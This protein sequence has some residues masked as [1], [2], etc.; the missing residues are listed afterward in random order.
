MMKILRKIGSGIKCM[1]GRTA[2]MLILSIVLVGILF[3][4][5]AF[6]ATDE[7]EKAL[8]KLQEMINTGFG[9]VH[10]VFWPILLMLG[11]LMDNDLIFGQEIGERLREIWVVIRNMVNIAFVFVLL[12]IA[13][14]NVTGLGGEGN[15]A[16]KTALPKFV[17]A[18]IAVNFSFL[19]CKVILDAAN[20]VSMAVYDIA[21]SI[22]AEEYEA[23]A[24]KQQLE[25][26]L[27]NSST[28][29]ACGRKVAPD[30]SDSG[31][32]NTTEEGMDAATS[33]EGAEAASASIYA[34]IAAECTEET[35]ETKYSDANP[36]A[37]AFC[38]SSNTD[39]DTPCENVAGEAVTAPQAENDDD[40]LIY[41]AFNDAGKSFFMQLDQNNIGIIMAINLGSLNHLTEVSSSGLSGSTGIKEI[42]IN[43]LFSVLMY[44]VFG[45][46]YIALFIVLLARLVVLW[47]VIALSPI[48][49]LT[50]VLPQMSQYTSELN[51]GEKFVQHL[52]APIIIGLSMSIGFLM[53]DKLNSEGA[54]GIDMGL[55]GASSYSALKDGS[56]TGTFLAPNISDL[57]QLMIACIAVAVVWLGVF[58]AADKTIASSVTSPIKD[59]GTKAAKFIA[60]LPTY[61]PIVPIMTKEGEEAKPYSFSEITS[62]MKDITNMP[63]EASRR[64]AAQLSADLGIRNNNS[65]GFND[66]MAK[67]KKAT[68]G[69]EKAVAIKEILGNMTES[70]DYEDFKDMMKS[71][72]HGI[73]VPPKWEDFDEWYA[74]DE[75]RKKMRAIDSTGGTPFKTGDYIDHSGDTDTAGSG[76]G[77]GGGGGKAGTPAQVTAVTN[78]YQTSTG[79]VASDTPEKKVDA[80]AAAMK[81]SVDMTGASDADLQAVLKAVTTADGS[82]VDPNKTGNLRFDNQGRLMIADSKKQIDAAASEE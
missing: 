18:L 52:M 1:M 51:L 22:D 9:L 12:V 38:C 53:T 44:I 15:F 41:P 14:Y 7:I 4:D 39:G 59:F 81:S 43:T 37:K 66:A 5:T 27:C 64:R 2:P 46:A 56:S 49:A 17:I 42:S 77:T 50:S 79:G 54:G 29:V 72:K 71:S 35:R 58:G 26:N 11:G 75:N 19:A 45:F 55:T 48:I 10:A 76:T 33:S 13:F 68:T 6:A 67:Y 80:A 23:D 31:T 69:K 25:F 30:D 8:M 74:K 63:E 65:Q 36:I 70:K 73:E 62:V 3:P 78:L 32:T 40:M 21:G 20:V 28:Y 57:Q 47:L 16:L 82:G 24:L 60:K 34:K 61:A